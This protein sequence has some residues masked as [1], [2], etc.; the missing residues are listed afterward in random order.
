MPA[1]AVVIRI[2]REG[3]GAGTIGRRARPVRRD[4]DAL[5]PEDTEHVGDANGA[6][7]RRVGAPVPFADSDFR[8]RVVLRDPLTQTWDQ[9]HGLADPGLVHV[10]WVPQSARRA[11]A[12]TIGR[13]VG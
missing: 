10:A 2:H 6:V 7:H 8:A 12:Y 5:T 4:I 1:V 9:H 3:A 11:D 13:L